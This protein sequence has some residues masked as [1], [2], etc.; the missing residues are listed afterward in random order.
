MSNVEIQP[1]DNT[2]IGNDDVVTV[3][4]FSGCKKVHYSSHEQN[5]LSNYK[6][7]NNKCC[8]NKV[9]N[10]IIGYKQNTN[11]VPKY[12]A[13]EV[14][15]GKDILIHHF[16][17]HQNVLFFTLTFEKAYMDISGTK[18]HFNSFLKKLKR[19]YGKLIY[20]YVIELQKERK[21]PSLHIHAAIKMVE[22][23]RF[24]VNKDEAEV[25]WGHGFIKAK[26]LYNVQKISSY[27]FKDFFREENLKIYPKNSHIYY[28]SQG[29][30]P[31]TVEKLTMTEFLEKYG[32]DY[33]LD[34]AIANNVIDGKTKKI[35]CSNI[36][37]FFKPRKYKRKSKRKFKLKIAIRFIKMEADKLLCDDIYSTTK[38]NKCFKTYGIKIPLDTKN[39]ILMNKV[40]K[41]KKGKQWIL[42]EST[43]PLGYGLCNAK[44]IDILDEK[45]ITRTYLF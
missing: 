45:D 12:V 19:R 44:V 10:K 39:T 20:F 26:R 35:M 32:D 28:S 22:Q 24:T 29:L 34:N 14:A 38:R 30:K 23:K 5:N 17:G 21:E 25:L 33:Y 11:K 13:R 18:K 42:L 27:F 2:W 9:T 7:L 1:S 15:R 41:L 16:S 40:R 31:P 37:K 43:F 3:K 8:I 36:D 6:K 4:H